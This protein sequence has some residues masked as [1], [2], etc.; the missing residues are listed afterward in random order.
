MKNSNEY[1]AEHAQLGGELLALTEAIDHYL[2]STTETVSKAKIDL[3]V[4]KEIAKDLL[5]RIKDE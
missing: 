4:R 1:M 2:N 3:V 5:D